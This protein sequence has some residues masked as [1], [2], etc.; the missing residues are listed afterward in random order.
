[1]KRTLLIFIIWFFALLSTPLSS[2]F[3]GETVTENKKVETIKELRENISELESE[4][5]QLKNDWQ[6]FLVENGNIEDFLKE[7]IVE[8]DESK[9]RE[10]IEIYTMY[11]T[12]VSNELEE[13]EDLEKQQELEKQLLILKQDLYKK[14]VYFIKPDRLDD[15]LTYVKWDL[16]VNQKRKN[17]SEEINEDT[18]KL[19]N[20]VNVIRDKIEENKKTLDERIRLVIEKKLDEKIWE[21][22][23][24]ERFI[25]LDVDSKKQLFAITLDKLRIQ[26]EKFQSIT[27]KTSLV[28][29]KIET[30]DIIEEKLIEVMNWF[31]T[32]SEQ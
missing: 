3:S 20:K 27:D 11:K 22:L 26:R 17:V 13:T 9:L 30:Y 29:K 5:R 10:I 1:M 14:L 28:N 18:K 23:A 2:A 12:G 8:E 32:E 25:Q 24:N 6:N 21:I 15:F 7:D 16:Q 31:E 19:E 4:K